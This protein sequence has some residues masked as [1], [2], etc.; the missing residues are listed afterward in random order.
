M[1]SQ[2]R[3]QR[4]STLWTATQLMVITSRSS[5]YPMPART[6]FTSA[7][8][9]VPGVP[10][11]NRDDLSDSSQQLRSRV[12][13]IKFAMMSRSAVLP[14]M[15]ELLLHVALRSARARAYIGRSA[16][17][18]VGG[19]VDNASA[20][21]DDAGVVG[22]PWTLDTDA[23]RLAPVRSSQRRNTMRT[24]SHTC[25]M[26]CRAGD[27][28]ARAPKRPC[29]RGTLW[30]GIHETLSAEWGNVFL[31]GVTVKN[32]ERCT[33]ALGFWGNFWGE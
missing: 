9:P 28:C 33:S 15:G 14:A 26:T 18:G 30:S 29:R 16:T 27:F 31:V 3:S 23:C 25:A 32:G 12:D 7:V 24:T 19:G 5:Q 8:L 21:I 11:I 2:R 1:C 22:S 17:G 6:E 10:E 4:A 20:D 13:A